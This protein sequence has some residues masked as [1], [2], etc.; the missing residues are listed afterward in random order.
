VYIKSNRFLFLI[1]SAKAK[2]GMPNPHITI[3][4]IATK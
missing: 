1:R 3:D 2:K 4:G